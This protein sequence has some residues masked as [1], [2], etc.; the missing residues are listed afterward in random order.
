MPEYSVSAE[1]IWVRQTYMRG[2]ELYDGWL[3][4]CIVPAL[5]KGGSPERAAAILILTAAWTTKLSVEGLHL[6][7]RVA[8]PLIIMIDVALA[9]V[10]YG[11]AMKANRVWT[12]LLASLQLFIVLAHVAKLIMPTL[13]PL[14]YYIILTKLAYP[15]AAIPA[16]GAL[17]H[18]LRLRALKI[19]EPWTSPTWKI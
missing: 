1:A 10:L 16:V 7:Y 17:R 13:D 18:Q 5:V 14:A 9:G 8:S 4:L 19:D 11:L 15:V 3:L 2:L 12:L 6:D